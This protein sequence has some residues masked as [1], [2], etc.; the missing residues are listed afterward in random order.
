M[1]PKE[2]V[3]VEKAFVRM[4]DGN[5]YYVDSPEATRA[6]AA[7]PVIGVDKTLQRMVHVGWSRGGWVELATVQREAA[8]HT[9]D[10]GMFVTMS[11]SEI[12]DLI[13]LLRRARDQAF[14]KDE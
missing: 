3:Y 6:L 10:A 11:R 5:E 1:M 8:E 13:R 2:N 9:L 12:N 7:D 14:G 4:K